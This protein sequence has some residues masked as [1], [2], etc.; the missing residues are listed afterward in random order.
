[1]NVPKQSQLVQKNEKRCCAQ[2]TRWCGGRTN[3]FEKF[4]H[5]L[6]NTVSWLWPLYL[7]PRIWLVCHT[8]WLLVFPLGWLCAGLCRL[9]WT[10][11]NAS[12]FYKSTWC[13]N[14]GFVCRVL[15]NL[16]RV[17][18]QGIVFIVLQNGCALLNMVLWF[19]DFSSK[20]WL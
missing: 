14:E 5:D 9:E 8:F 20:A 19:S 16:T 7:H 1:M 15:Q 18:K 6:R 17:S 3:S 11:L 4:I 12:D 10:I 2:E 13:R